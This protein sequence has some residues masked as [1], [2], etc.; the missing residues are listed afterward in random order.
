MVSFTMPASQTIE[1]LP[2][3]EDQRVNLRQVPA[4]R[5]AAVRYSGT[6]S[7]KRYIQYKG[8]LESWIGKKGFSIIGEAVWARYNPPFTPWFLRRNE[9]LIPVNTDL[10]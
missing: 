6:W 3:P 8:E 5:M 1:S 2:A 4:L 9:I 10:K 7:E